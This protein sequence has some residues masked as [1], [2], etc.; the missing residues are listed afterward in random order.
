LGASVSA[1]FV[2]F[3]PA[4]KTPRL[5]RLD[6]SAPCHQ[7]MVLDSLAHQHYFLNLAK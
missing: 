3:F 2:G 7:P 4:Q 6:R 1:Y 5:D